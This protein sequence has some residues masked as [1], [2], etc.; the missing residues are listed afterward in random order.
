[1]QR[2]LSAFTM[3]ICIVLAGRGVC[4]GGCICMSHML[5]VGG[6]H[7]Q[8]VG[9]RFALPFVASCF[10]R[11]QRSTLHIR[12]V[13]ILILSCR[14]RPRP[15]PRR[16]RRRSRHRRRCRKLGGMLPRRLR[17]RLQPLPC[18]LAH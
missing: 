12:C 3:W 9:S 8:R 18:S 2:K 11:V 6:L 5:H 16:M 7:V 1:V 17:R 13:G 4:C 15:R 14:R 10:S